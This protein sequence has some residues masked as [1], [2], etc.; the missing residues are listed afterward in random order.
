MASI[1]SKF[2][3]KKQKTLGFEQKPRTREEINQEYNHHAVM[4]GHGATLIAEVEKN[5]ETLQADQQRHLEATMRLRAEAAKLPADAPA[6][7]AT[8]ASKTNE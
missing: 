5:L 2:T 8:E 3:K 6:V 1:L 7:A 4:L